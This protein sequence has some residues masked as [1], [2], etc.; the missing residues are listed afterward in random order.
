MCKKVVHKY[1][2]K[3]T[4]DLLFTDTQKIFLLEGLSIAPSEGSLLKEAFFSSHFSFHPQTAKRRQRL[5]QLKTKINER[6]HFQG[7]WILSNAFNIWHNVAFLYDTSTVVCL[8]GWG[9][10]GRKLW[11]IPLC[12]F[13][14]MGSTRV[15]IS[16]FWGWRMDLIF[17]LD[18]SSLTLVEFGCL[19]WLG[20]WAAVVYGAA[21]FT[22]CLALGVEREYYLVL[23]IVM[24]PGFEFYASFR[25]NVIG[26]A[27]VWIEVLVGMWCPWGHEELCFHLSFFGWHVILL[28]LRYDILGFC[29]ILTARVRLTSFLASKCMIPC[30]SVL[31]LRMVWLRLF[32]SSTKILSFSISSTPRSTA[33]L[34][35]SQPSLLGTHPTTKAILCW[36]K[37]ISRLVW[38]IFLQSKLHFQKSFGQLVVNGDFA[39]EPVGTLA[40]EAKELAFDAFLPQLRSQKLDQL[41][42]I[43]GGYP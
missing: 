37:L 40:D 27:R 38:P 3:D 36:W 43:Q 31:I 29:L 11:W 17:G 28:V 2:L 13:F 42:S 14:T 9:P 1:L 35:A 24:S 39:Q 19:W 30:S 22:S 32:A 16:F 15:I 4:N 20:A 8:V 26:Y 5:S 12:H 34:M 21:G 7:K 18:V 25:L 6:F 23:V 10:S 33:T 41:S